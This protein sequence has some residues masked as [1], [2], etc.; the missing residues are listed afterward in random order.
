M[1]VHV[2]FSRGVTF[3]VLFVGFGGTVFLLLFK[4]ANIMIAISLFVRTNV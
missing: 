2:S 4:M 1:V 3:A